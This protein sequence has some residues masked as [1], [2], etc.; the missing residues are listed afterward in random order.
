MDSVLGDTEDPRKDLYFLRSEH[1]WR[2]R[3]NTQ[4]REREIL[5]ILEIWEIMDETKEEA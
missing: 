2:Q 4:E 3:K 1:I 5:K